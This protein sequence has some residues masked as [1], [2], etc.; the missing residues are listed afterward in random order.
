MSDELIQV[1]RSHAG[2]AVLTLQR[3][4]KRN[5][6]NVVLLQQ[7]ASA[8]EHLKQDPGCRVLILRGDGPVFCAGLDL[9]EASDARLAEESAEGV[10]HILSLLQESPLIVIAA[11]HGA[12]MAGG[13]GLLAVS[14]LVVAADNLKL[15][16]PEVRRG[17]V[18]ALVSGPLARKIRGGDLRELLLL[19]EPITAMRAQQMGLVQWIVPSDQ[20]LE[21]ALN[22]A[23]RVL[24]GGPDA[25][26]ETKR[27]LYQDPTAVDLGFL[28]A[29]HERVRHGCEARE[30]LAAFRERR[31]PNWRQNS[32]G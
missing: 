30:G 11:A 19:G 4:E 22:L 29:L 9:V 31:E 16:F 1:D 24:A 5:A 3:A 17:L 20:V 28:K 10:R 14:D 21:H 15:G 25:V 32:E 26:R 23:R 18:A 2:I 8:V 6:L 7:L 13:A 27:L 12:A